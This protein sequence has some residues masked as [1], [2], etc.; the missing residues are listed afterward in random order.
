MKKPKPAKFDGHIKGKVI[1][2]KDM[3]KGM[4]KPKVKKMC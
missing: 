1:K 4:M 2:S 3:M